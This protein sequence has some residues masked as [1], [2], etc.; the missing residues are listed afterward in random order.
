MFSV[1]SKTDSKTGRQQWISVD[2]DRNSIGFW[3]GWKTLVD[4]GR[5]VMPKGGLGTMNVPVVWF[6]QI[7][8]LAILLK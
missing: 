4:F 1:D 3:S 7:F 8:R 6:D 5:R 2:E